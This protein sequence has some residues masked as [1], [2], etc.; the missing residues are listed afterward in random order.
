[1]T[2]NDERLGRLGDGPLRGGTSGARVLRALVARVTSNDAR[3]AGAVARLL[4]DGLCDAEGARLGSVRYQH[5]A[6]VRAR[7]SNGQPK[8]GAPLSVSTINKAWRAARRPA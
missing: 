6:A 2:L 8:T 4:S 7:S 5:T 1:M 3:G